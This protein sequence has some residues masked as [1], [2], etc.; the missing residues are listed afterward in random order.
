MCLWHNYWFLIY[1]IL[2]IFLIATISLVLITANYDILMKIIV[3]LFNCHFLYF[4]VFWLYYLLRLIVLLHD[5][6]WLSYHIRDCD[7]GL[8]SRTLSYWFGHTP[9]GARSSKS[10]G[11]M[12]RERERERDWLF[13]CVIQREFLK[14]TVWDFFLSKS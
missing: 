13:A 6:E 10:I 5:A 7:F 8:L 3:S 2:E 11:D 1:S 9:G 12:R 4:A 14:M